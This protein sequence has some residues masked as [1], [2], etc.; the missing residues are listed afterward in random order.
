MHC[1]HASYLRTLGGWQGFAFVGWSRGKH[2]NESLAPITITL[3]LGRLAYRHRRGIMMLSLTS[4]YCVL[5]M[6]KSPRGYLVAISIR[7]NGPQIHPIGHSMLMFIK[8]SC[9]SFMPCNPT[10]F[11]GPPGPFILPLLPV[12]FTLSPET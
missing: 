4:L 6:V 9:V 11:E 5:Q 8:P 7:A 2:L 10:R 3:I 12:L 1:Y